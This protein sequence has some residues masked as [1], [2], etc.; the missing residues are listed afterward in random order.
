MVKK[1]KPSVKKSPKV[2]SSSL[3]G[4]YHPDS[5]KYILKKANGKPISVQQAERY[6]QEWA[7]EKIKKSKPQ[8]STEDISN[9][10]QEAPNNA[11][12]R[13]AAINPQF[14][15]IIED[16]TNGVRATSETNSELHRSI[17]NFRI[18]GTG[19]SHV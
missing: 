11:P 18:P 15:K 3:K 12:I 7:A 5:V 1:T 4:S 10:M 13:G 8:A 16:K 9:I 14:K 6:D 2:S 19:N 17:V